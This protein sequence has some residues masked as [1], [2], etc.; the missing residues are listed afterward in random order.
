MFLRAENDAGIDHGSENRFAGGGGEPETS[1]E[2]HRILAR[3][4]SRADGE[5]LVEAIAGDDEEADGVALDA[6]ERALEREGD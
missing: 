6:V 4:P 3:G 5:H 2:P 1:N